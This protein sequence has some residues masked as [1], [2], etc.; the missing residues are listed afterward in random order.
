MNWN[1]LLIILI[2]F[3]HIEAWL[4]CYKCT[5]LYPSDDP[6][7]TNPTLNS[8]SITQDIGYDSC[9]VITFFVLFLTFF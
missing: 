8:S 5:S 2:T 9:M 1:F 6:C 7:A 4:Q 3:G